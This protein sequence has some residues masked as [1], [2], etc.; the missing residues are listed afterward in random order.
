VRPV[1]ENGRVWRRPDAGV[2]DD[3]GGICGGAAFLARG[4]PVRVVDSQRW[5]VRGDRPD[6]DH[7]GVAL[8]T[9]SVDAVEVPG[10]GDGH[11]LALAR[12]EFPVR[13]HR[14]VDDDVHGSPH[15]TGVKT[16]YGPG[17]R[18]DTRR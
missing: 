18:C 15:G 2:R 5:V 7:D 10:P 6:A 14:C 9:Q 1:V 13:A 12:R 8:G 3:A 4:P 16:A 17:R 11:L